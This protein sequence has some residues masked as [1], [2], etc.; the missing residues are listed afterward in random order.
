MGIQR[1]GLLLWTE[2][3]SNHFAACFWSCNFR[4]SAWI[5]WD[6]CLR[7]E[8]SDLLWAPI[9]TARFSTALLLINYQYLSACPSAIL[10]CFYMG[11]LLP[12]SLLSDARGNKWVVFVCK[13]CLEWYDFRW[14]YCYLKTQY[15]AKFFTTENSLDKLLQANINQLNLSRSKYHSFQQ[16]QV[17]SFLPPPPN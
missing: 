17:K 8:C 10:Y 11:I 14:A 9:V 13:S 7:K 1:G 4:R 15:T 2:G 12:Q 16:E 6:F 3:S 5:W